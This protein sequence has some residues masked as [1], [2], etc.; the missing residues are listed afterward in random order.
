M[1]TAFMVGLVVLDAVLIAVLGIDVVRQ[2]WA[3][4]DMDGV[5]GAQAAA[6]SAP[7][8]TDEMHALN[9]AA[10]G[11]VEPALLAF[12]AAHRAGSP[13]ADRNTVR[14]SEAL[15]D[16]GSTARRPST[17]TLFWH[18][19]TAGRDG[20]K[21]GGFQQHPVRLLQETL[22]T[23]ALGAFGIPLL[24]VAVRRITL[25][26]RGAMAAA[27]AAPEQ[28]TRSAS[29]SDICSLDSVAMQRRFATARRMHE[30]RPRTPEELKEALRETLRGAAAVLG[31]EF[32]VVC[33]IDGDEAEIDA[34]ISPPGTLCDGQRFA[35]RGTLCELTLQ[36]DDLV[37]FGGAAH[38]QLPTSPVPRSAHPG[39]YLGVP[40]VTG[41]EAWGMVCFW[42]AQPRQQGFDAIDG[43]FVRLIASLMVT[44]TA[45]AHLCESHRLTEVRLG[46][47]TA[48][49]EMKAKGSIAFLAAMSHEIRT[50]LN[51]IIGVT[52]LMTR[53]YL[54][55]E[56]QHYIA[57][58]ER[59]GQHLIELT[60]D[61]LNVAKLDSGSA[62][63]QRDHLN[64]EGVMQDVVFLLRE[65]MEAK[66]L[67]VVLEAC[68]LPDT[69]C[70]DRTRLRQMLLNYGGNAVKFT[71]QGTIAF[72]VMIEQETDTQLLLRFEVEDT[73]PGLDEWELATLFQDYQQIER[74]QT[75]DI[76]GTGLGLAINKRLAE[77]LGGTVGAHS[78][79][80][81]GS[82][83]WFTARFDKLSALDLLTTD[84]DADA[85]ALL[86][87]RYAGARILLVEDEAESAELVSELLHFSCLSVDIAQS[88]GV[89]I[90][91]AKSNDYALILMDLQLPG[92]N[93]IEATRRIRQIYGYQRTPVVAMTGNAF[94]EDRARCAAVGMNDFLPKPIVTRVLF[95]TILRCLDRV[96][97]AVTAP[98]D[99]TVSTRVAGGIRSGVAQ[100][101]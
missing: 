83:F 46:E 43:E 70:G 12:G 87:A 11:E 27:F 72:R 37:M 89:A 90:E 31:M 9:R 84:D 22:S 24:L 49:A 64:V 42:S 73:G 52:E 94:E 99:P 77:T 7:F 51:V 21:P 48:N 2:T 32:A 26:R 58:I 63:R 41:D 38:G 16:V 76:E 10:A 29:A 69:V 85:E 30:L 1:R 92:L 91:M 53:H 57:Q 5:H 25:A 44:V 35:L 55:S 20:G 71:R 34:E 93:G 81:V 100:R 39:A 78:I 28:A 101:A 8:T 97:G 65:K 86:K 59:A 13:A 61:I 80:G 56:Q 33:R 68:P 74:E 82:T 3:A 47:L 45:H 17:L 19:I 50:P 98:P 54:P 62:V 36:R 96:R 88:G 66:G 6:A 18:D 14:R 79:P 40:L 4:A 95:A 60:R 67:A 75:P 15:Q 23:L